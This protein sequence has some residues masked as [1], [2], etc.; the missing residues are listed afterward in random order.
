MNIGYFS[1]K[2]FKKIRLKVCKNL[3]ARN[4]KIFTLMKTKKVSTIKLAIFFGG[5]KVWA[6]TRNKDFRIL[7]SQIKAFFLWID[8]KFRWGMLILDEGTCFLYTLSKGYKHKPTTDCC[9]DKRQLN[10][11]SNHSIAVISLLSENNREYI[12][13]ELTKFH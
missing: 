13:C 12:R 7:I 8:A 6:Q 10:K 4:T 9:T 1:D 2:I 11:P 3:R 5:V